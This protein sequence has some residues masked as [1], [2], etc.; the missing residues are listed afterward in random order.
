M[1]PSTLHLP[2]T[3][4]CYGGGK[5]NK[6][7]IGIFV[8][9]LMIAIGV[10]PIVN[11]EI[12]HDQLVY[13]NA[14]A[15]VDSVSDD[16][17]CGRSDGLDYRDFR[18]PVM[19]VIYEPLDPLYA[20]PKPLAL[21]NLPEY[22][23][24]L[25]YEGE[26]WTSPVKLQG[27]GDCWDF[28]AIGTLESIINIREHNP[29]LDLDLSEQ[30]VLSCLPNSGGCRGGSTYVAFDD[31][32]ESL[33]DGAYYNG[34]LPESCFP[35]VGV[36]LY[37]YN[38]SESGLEPVLCS[39][40]C[41]NWNENLIPIKECG[42]WIPDGSSEDRDVI[43]TQ[44]MQHGPVCTA[45]FVTE[46]FG[47]W[48]A[49]CHNSTDYYPYKAAN[50][51][52]HAVVIVGWMDDASLTKG[53]YW[54]TKNS[55]GTDWGYNGFFNIEYNSLNIDK[56]EIDWVDYDANRSQWSPN[57]PIIDGP[58][59]AGIEEECTFSTSTS[60]PITRDLQYQ[61][62]WGDGSESDWLGPY[63]SGTLITSSHSWTEKGLYQVR[64]KAKNSDN[65]ASQWSD[66]IIVRVP[67]GNNGTDQVQHKYQGGY[68]CFGLSFAQ[69]FIPSETSLTK[70]SLYMRE[71][72]DAYRIRISIRDRLDGT[73]LTFIEL[74]AESISDTFR[75]QEFDF[76]DINVISGQ[77]YY[78]VWSPYAY[79][80]NNTFIWGFGKDN[81]YP[82][83]CAWSDLGGHW[84]ELV[85][86][87]Y[88]DPDFCFKTY[89]AKHKNNAANSFIKILEQN[90]NI[91]KLLR[92]LKGF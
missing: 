64:V 70:V 34:A 49:K 91:F 13:E 2:L 89:F 84:E 83:G 50:G 62:E 39:E 10:L 60:D 57:K 44:I 59:E 78:I 75:W 28:A 24:W 65:A 1:N 32:K 80:I 79:D 38:F 68:R 6:K 76:P 3:S 22:F 85:I 19:N 4:I 63:E 46:Q 40:K 12:E 7:L 82:D 20:S 23:S 30:Y 77:T 48:G 72:G 87:N 14:G 43:K 16:C 29:E 8:C 25:D 55:W 69:S 27:C 11:S 52:N 67:K 81:Q 31:M 92:Q 54:I 26:D 53:G 66:L 17:G 74:D 73:D 5:M 47:G 58:D 56:F 45:M 35:Y 9:T 90:Q 21:E 33:I 36:D 88:P 15:K 51:I 61:F 37:G 18:F 42:Y 86:P 41:E 71:I